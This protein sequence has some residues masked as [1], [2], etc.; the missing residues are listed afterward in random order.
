MAEE[1]IHIYTHKLLNCSVLIQNDLER[2]STYKVHKDK[3][4]V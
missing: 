3:I 2:S 4:S 1:I